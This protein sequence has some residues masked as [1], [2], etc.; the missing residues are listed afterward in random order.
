MAGFMGFYTLFIKTHWAVKFIAVAGFINCFF[1]TAIYFSFTS[2]ILMMVSFYF[3][4]LCQSIKNY[5]F[6]FNV[7]KCVMIYIGFM[8]LIQITGNDTLLN[9]GGGLTQ[10]GVVGHH[11]QSSSFAVI[12]SAVLITLSP[13][14]LLLIVPVS[15]ICNSVGAFL[16]GCIG[17]VF[18]LKWKDNK[19]FL[20]PILLVSSVAVS[21]WLVL[22]GKLQSNL[23]MDLGRLGTWD[24]TILLSLQHPFIGWGVGTF[25]FLYPA[26]GKTGTNYQW[27]MAHNCWLQMI[28]ELGYLIT[29][30]LMFYYGQLIY[31]LSRIHGKKAKLC[32]AGLLMI[33]TNMMFHFP[34]RMIQTVFIIIFFLA[35]C[36]RIVNDGGDVNG[37]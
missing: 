6:V 16:C 32:I 25:H 24:S 12:L 22:S 1:S 13:L 34:T 8:F 26:L 20:I 11:M 7:L 3:Y 28:F 5:D 37:C 10:F 30:V 4:I 18:C 33:G 27:M 15:I 35:Y 36:Q 19:K 31:R 23:N 17:L 2:Y 9:Y 29:G 14:F 21:S